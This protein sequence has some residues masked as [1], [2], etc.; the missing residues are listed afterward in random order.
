MG[1]MAQRA[2]MFPAVHTQ[3]T[4]ALGVSAERQNY[5]KFTW[6]ES[7]RHGLGGHR[8]TDKRYTESRAIPRKVGYPC[9][10]HTPQSTEVRCGLQNTGEEWTK[11]PA[12][13]GHAA[14]PMRGSKLPGDKKRLN[15]PAMRESG[16]WQVFNNP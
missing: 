6:D 15:L 10:H 7:K 9:L 11:N 1:S 13:E 5:L 8:P 4:V 16:I 14:W 12:S 2:V 3:Y